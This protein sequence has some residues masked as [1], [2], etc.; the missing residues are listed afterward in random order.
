VGGAPGAA[1]AGGEGAGGFVVFGWRD[2]AAAGCAWGSTTRCEG[3]EVRNAGDWWLCSRG[4][5]SSVTI[6]L[7]WER[8]RI[9]VN[10]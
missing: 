6:S 5:S 10:L 8:F 1:S 2:E 4:V 9:D 7:D 3:W